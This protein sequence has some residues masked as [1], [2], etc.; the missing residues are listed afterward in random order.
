MQLV[1]K[2]ISN[3][4]EGSDRGNESGPSTT[5]KGRSLGAKSQ[6]CVQI[7]IG[8]TTPVSAVT[9][10]EVTSKDGSP[11]TGVL[12]LKPSTI[13]S[14]P[15]LQPAGSRRPSSSTL[16]VAVRHTEGSS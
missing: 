8:R 10:V 4:D 6:A 7:S 5:L 1:T 2:L 16:L 11:C 12:K 9:E 3:C 13:R 14:M 15:V